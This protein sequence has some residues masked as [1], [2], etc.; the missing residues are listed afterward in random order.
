MRISIAPVDDKVNFKPVEV[1]TIDELVKHATTSNY[2]MGVFKDNYRKKNNFQKAEA[3]AIDV[4]NDGLNDNYTIVDAAEKFAQYK[5]I[6]MPSK[7]HQKEKNGKV[8]DRFR[9]ILF[10]DKA[11]TDAKDFQATW[12][13][14]YDF[15]PAAD[16][17]CK[18][19][20]RFF[21]PSPEVY[22]VN[23]SGKLWPTAEYVKPDLQVVDPIDEALKGQLSKQTLEF[24]MNGAPEGKRNQSLFKAAKDMQEQGYGMAE[25][26]KRLEVMIE[27][28]GSWG[29]DYV[30]DKDLECIQNAFKDDPIYDKREGEVVRPSVF[31]FQTLDELVENAEEINWLVDG[32]LSDGGFS[33]IVGPPKGG[34]S[35]LIRQMA[36][37]VAQGKPFLGRNVTQGGVLYLTFEEQGGLLRDQF[38][39]AGR[40]PGDEI[41][42][43]I[44]NVF[45][46]RE[47]VY[48]DL[49]AGI[50][51]YQ[52]SLL[53]LDT[54]FDA[55][56]LESINDYGEVKDALARL[57][58][59]ARNTGCHIIGVHH[60][61]KTGDGNNSIMGSNGI[62]AALDTL[63]RFVQEGE[64]R[65][66]F[67]NGKGGKHFINQEI[68][69]DHK[70]ERYSLGAKRNK[71]RDDT[72]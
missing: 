26:I 61:N 18:D 5:H 25:V 30:C 7:S 53:V 66:L 54:I 14:I 48:R 43:H 39:A 10:L 46:N 36:L 42:I 15:Y 28:G 38:N 34:K 44:G 63:V 56:H 8:K 35:T 6:I 16:R 9:V 62:H 19:A 69:F 33:L 71:R 21:F 29:I 20:S 57:R 72:L 67:T 40:Q 68:I 49:E 11:I 2:S 70:T 1:N 59:I 47:I 52:P 13:T 51:E 58:T 24:F 31:K 23:N 65:Y 41:R 50:M 64:R 37:A 45:E 4:D 27:L 12:K 3:I 32:L 55:F 60:V 22:S 17:A